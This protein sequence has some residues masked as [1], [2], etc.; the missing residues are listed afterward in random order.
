MYGAGVPSLGTEA[1]QRDAQLLDALHPATAVPEQVLPPVFPERPGRAL[2]SPMAAAA[3]VLRVGR[4]ADLRHELHGARV[5][6]PVAAPAR[7]LLLLGLRVHQLLRFWQHGGLLLLSAAGPELV[8][9]QSDDTVCAAAPGLARGLH[10]PHCC[11]PRARAARGLRAGCGLHSGLLQEPHRLVLLPV[12]ASH[13][14]L[15]HAA[16]HGLP[17]HA[18]ELA[19]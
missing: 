12:R 2:P 3:V 5:Q 1:Y 10:T 15:R 19:V 17:H 14:C 16:Q 7:C 13:F 8:G 18:R 4:A 9:R 11:L 6:L